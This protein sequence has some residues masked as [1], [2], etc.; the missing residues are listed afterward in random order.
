MSHSTLNEYPFFPQINKNDFYDL[1]AKEL[2]RASGNDALK[3]LLWETEQSISFEPYFNSS[4]KL[5][6]EFQTLLKA[7]SFPSQ[8]NSVLIIDLLRTT[9]EHLS[10]IVSTAKDLGCSE[11]ILKHFSDQRPNVSKTLNPNFL[12]GNELKVSHLF[13]PIQLQGFSLEP[14]PIFNIK[15]HHFYPFITL[16]SDVKSCFELQ[17]A[18]VINPW[19]SSMELVKMG[20]S[21]S[22]E[23]ASILF[24]CKEVF[25]HLIENPLRS[26]IQNFSP[27][28]EV[29]ASGSLYLDILKLRALRILLTLLNQSI[30]SQS[31]EKPN[32]FH[33]H[34]SIPE[35]LVSIFDAHNNVLRSTVACFAGILGGADT[36]FLPS[37]DT[38]LSNKT[39]SSLRLSLLIHQLLRH[40]SLLGLVNDAAR[41]SYFFDTATEQFAEVT[42]KKFLLIEAE[43]GLSRSL[44]EGSFGNDLREYAKKRNV[45]F[46][47]RKRALVGI[48][49]YADSHED[50][51]PRE[52]LMKSNKEDFNPSFEFESIR[53][54][55][56]DA[57]KQRSSPVKVALLLYGDFAKRSARADFATDV[58][59]SGGIRTERI[60]EDESLPKFESYDGIVFCSNDES[61]LQMV[62]KFITLIPESVPVIIAGKQ[63]NAQELVSKGISDFIYFGMNVP[64]FLHKFAEKYILK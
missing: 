22:D 8:W 19:I 58:F 40:E 29:F 20:A 50:P 23:L 35:H 42:W 36:I 11:I 34:F 4:N 5:S 26:T 3:T 6:P 46:Q 39:E 28:F 64:E 47:Q 2:K 62:E 7:T 48:S 37:Y 56:I 38:K 51:T 57:A 49:K 31:Q 54:K 41:G 14:S 63:A 21:V 52:D 16:E 24:L 60:S 15:T 45:Q 55:I 27:R 32:T 53:L 10:H 30:Q 33:I 13:S 59:A 17:N 18:H 9:D 44:L 61:Y 43:G 12:Y 1:V 25:T